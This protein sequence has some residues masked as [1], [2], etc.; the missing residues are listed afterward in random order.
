MVFGEALKAL[1]SG[2][3]IIRAGWAL[4]EGYLALMAGMKH[5]WKILPHPTPNAGNHV[6]SIDEL[7]ADDW[8]LLEERNKEVIE[9]EA[10]AA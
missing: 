10:D 1:E 5:I 8:Q 2:K 9:Q 6:L 3:N 4:E 7:N